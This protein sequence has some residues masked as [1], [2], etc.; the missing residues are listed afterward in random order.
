MLP[1][2]SVRWLCYKRTLTKLDQDAEFNRATFHI[3]ESELQKRGSILASE[4]D[5]DLRKRF[6]ACFHV[7]CQRI[8][9][10]PTDETTEIFADGTRI[11]VVPP[12]RKTK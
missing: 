11:K 12:K 1:N 2:R 7:L 3:E 10:T 9:I 4:D 8:E 6:S 5:E